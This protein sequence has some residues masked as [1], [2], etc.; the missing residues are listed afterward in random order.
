MLKNY[1]K[2]L[3]QVLLVMSLTTLPVSSSALDIVFDPANYKQWLIDIVFTKGTEWP[4][5]LAEITRQI[6]ELNK[7]RNQVRS[8]QFFLDSGDLISALQVVAPYL[9]EEAINQLALL[10]PMAGNFTEMVEAIIHSDLGHEVEDFTEITTLMTSIGS[11]ATDYQDSTEYDH[12]LQQLYIDEVRQSAEQDKQAV[13]RQQTIETLNQTLV[14]LGDESEVASLQLIA[15]QMQL[16]AR[17]NEQ[18]IRIM[19]DQSVAASQ[20]KLMEASYRAKQRRADIDRAV[21]KHNAPYQYSTW[22]EHAFKK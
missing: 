19:T 10:D 2:F 5:R 12:R 11:S 4:A 8:V 13:L 22:T 1:K 20:E 7:L 17:Q 15:S 14:S 9:G 3:R 16:L 21:S 6:E 18:L